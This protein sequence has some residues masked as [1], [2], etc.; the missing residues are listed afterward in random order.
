M[1]LVCTLRKVKPRQIGQEIVPGIYWT[2][3][4]PNMFVYKY[5]RHRGQIYCNV[6]RCERREQAMQLIRQRHSQLEFRFYS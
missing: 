3:Q 2:G 1:S 4:K 5:E 6:V